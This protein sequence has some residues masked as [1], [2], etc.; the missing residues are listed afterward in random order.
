[1]GVS[2]TSNLYLS[3]PNNYILLKL[4][5]LTIHNI[6]SI[7]D[8][9]IDFSKAPLA[10]ADVF[11]IAGDTGA[12]KSTVLDAISLALYGKTPRLLNSRTSAI[13]QGGEQ[14]RVT[15][16]GQLLRRNTGE[17]FVRLSFIGKNGVA[18]E[19]VWS[20]RRAH[21][22]PDGALR[23]PVRTLLRDGGA[24]PFEGENEIKREIAEAIG[25]DFEQFTRTAMLAQGEFA[26][27]LKSDD[28]EKASILEK[29]TGTGQ[30]AAIGRRV[31]EIFR[32]KEQKWR[33]TR[34]A[35]ESVVVLPNA[36]RLALR[37]QLASST[38][39]GRVAERK[40]DEARSTL[41]CLENVRK[42][43]KV[44]EEN[45][46]RLRALAAELEAL[47]A[48]SPDCA[49]ESVDALRRSLEKIAEQTGEV[50]E[51]RQEAAWVRESAE[52]CDAA[53][54][55][56]ATLREDMAR[57]REREAALVPAVRAAVAAEETAR[58]VYDGQKDTVDRFAKLARARLKVGDVCPVCR[59]RVAALPDPE[60]VLREIVEGYREAW[61]R[62]AESRNAL[63]GE[64][65]KVGGALKAYAAREVKEARS[66]EVELPR[67]EERG[68]SLA[69]RV[70]GMG[71]E[72]SSG[73][74]GRPGSVAEVAAAFLE[75]LLSSLKERQKVT[76]GRLKAA[77]AVA[78]C[79]LEMEKTRERVRGLSEYRASMLSRL[80]ADVS[81]VSE[82]SLREE[83]KRL[84]DLGRESVRLR[85]S[86]SQQLADD[87]AARSRHAALAACE[88]ERRNVYIRWHNLNEYIGSADGSRFRRV[89]QSYVLRN[90]VEAANHYMDSLSGR[91][92]LHT[93]SDSFVISVEDSWQGGA[94]RTANTLSGGESFLV[95]L[96]L[97]L[98]LSDI[99]ENLKMDTLFIDEGFGTLSGE[100]LR[101][102]VDTLRALHS[103]TGRH[104]GI[105][106]HIEELRER[107]PVQ[108][109]VEQDPRSSASTV[110]IV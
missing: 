84:L 55:S 83:L 45:T 99:G 4:K 58:I 12:G 46:V 50:R 60:D 29:I 91:Y 27:F 104:V 24:S 89:A 79:R 72:F 14:V 98:A 109:L 33:E 61:R 17:G 41:D 37:R 6:A 51:L 9:E 65:H 103:R 69:S 52:R 110:R 74:K 63:E 48:A 97:A 59:Q 96:S 77:E 76:E 22:R 71:L 32:E 100:P 62:A 43:D 53:S 57:L 92:R 93:A 26:K 101:K 94:L 80:P 31:N 42:A 70:V 106:S 75:G 86:L 49:E 107:I 39:I 44:M 87:A 78:R 66:L 16:P 54:R 40:A 11:L 10:D 28:K 82:D 35:L 34:A 2:P 5:T 15:N 38:L 36:R 30:Y 73:D 1:M 20:I 56:L 19:A 18:Y 13:E 88:E 7:T 68:R 21:R 8:A 64:L 90:L 23:N 3:S 25:L 102:A 81:A 67:I 85:G 105:I 108:L 47:V 95:S